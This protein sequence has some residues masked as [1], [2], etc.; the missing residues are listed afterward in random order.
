MRNF[1]CLVLLFGPHSIFASTIFVAGEGTLA[2]G[3]YLEERRKQDNDSQEYVYATWVG[4][5]LTAANYYFPTKAM[6]TLPNS[7]TVLAY[8]DKYCRENP[9][10][11]L[12]NGAVKLDQDIKADR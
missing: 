12:V 4:G 6:R 11:L 5:F 2:C 10:K 3:T 1:I 8:L 9:L 7:A